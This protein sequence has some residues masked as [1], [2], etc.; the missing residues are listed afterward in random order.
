MAASECVLTFSEAAL[1]SVSCLESCPSRVFQYFDDLSKHNIALTLPGLLSLA[2]LLYSTVVDAAATQYPEQAYLSTAAITRRTHVDNT[3][4]NKLSLA[5]SAHLPPTGKAK[6]ILLAI[7][8]DPTR[9]PLLLPGGD[10]RSFGEEQVPGYVAGSTIALRAA[11][12]AEHDAAIDVIAFQMNLLSATLLSDLIT[13]GVK[14]VPVSV[15]LTLRTCTTATQAIV[16]LYEKF[17]LRQVDEIHQHWDLVCEQYLRELANFAHDDYRGLTSFWLL[18][19]LDTYALFPFPTVSHLTRLT[20][21]VKVALRALG[22]FHHNPDYDK[23][24]DRLAS[25]SSPLSLSDV[26]Q[27]LAL[28]EDRTAIRDVEASRVTA[29]SSGGFAGPFSVN[30]SSSSFASSSSNSTSLSSRLSTQSAAVTTAAPDSRSSSGGKMPSQYFKCSQASTYSGPTDTAPLATYSGQPS[31]PSA[32][33]SGQPA[34]YSGQ[35][36]SLSAAYSGQHSSPSAAFSG[37]SDLPTLASTDDTVLDSGC[38]PGHVITPGPHVSFYPISRQCVPVTTASGTSTITCMTGSATIHT[39]CHKGLPYNVQ[40]PGTSLSSPLLPSSLISLRTLLQH[41]FVVTK[42]DADTIVLQCPGTPIRFVHLHPNARGLWTFPPPPPAISSLASPLVVSTSSLALTRSQAT[43]SPLYSRPLTRLIARPH[44][45]ATLSPLSTT[46]ASPS[47]SS[48][49]SQSTSPSPLRSVKLDTRAHRQS[50]PTEPTHLTHDLDLLDSL[51]AAHGHVNARRLRLIVKNMLMED[52]NRPALSSMYQWAFYRKCVTCSHADMER[53]NQAATH[54]SRTSYLSTP[55]PGSHLTMDGSGAFSSATNSGMTSAWIITDTCSHHRVVCPVPSRA[56]LS[57]LTH[58]RQYIADS[59]TMPTHLRIDNELNVDSFQ[60]FCRDNLISLSACAPH[61]HQGNPIAESSVRCVKRVA[62]TNAV[63]ACTGVHLHDL[64]LQYAARQLNRSPTSSD[65]T[66]TNRSPETMWPLAPGNHPSQELHPWACLV[67]GFVGKRSTDPNNAPR[68]ALGIFVG[69]A[70]HTSGYLVYDLDTSAVTTYGYVDAFPTRFPL[71][72]RDL[73]GEHPATLL[74]GQWRQWSAFRLNE[75]ADGPLSEFLCGKQIQVNLPTSFYPSYKHSW[76]VLCQRPVHHASGIYSIRL[77]FTKYNGPLDELSPDDAACLTEGATPLFIDVLLSPLGPGGVCPPHIVSS[78]CVRALL[79][80]TFP[81]VHRLHEL[82]DANVRL[83]G[84]YPTHPAAA[85][86]SDAVPDDTFDDDCD[87]PERVTRVATDRAAKSSRANF[88]V[89]PARTVGSTRSSKAQWQPSSS[90]IIPDRQHM[91]LRPR[92]PQSI[93]VVSSQAVPTSYIRVLSTSPSSGSIG[94]EPRNFRE[95]RSHA[96]WPQ[97]QAAILKEV[98]GLESRGT[99]EA[100]PIADVPAG[101]TI[102]GSQ[103]VFRDKAVPKARL[104]VRGDQ[105]RPKPSSADTYAST[106][107]ATEVRILFSLATQ[108]NWPIHSCDIAQAFTQSHALSPGSDLYIHPPMGYPRTPGIVWRLK[109]PLYGLCTAPKAW[110]DTL[111]E[112]VRDYGFCSVNCSDT[113]YTYTHPSSGASIHLVFHVD[114]ILFSFSTDDV[115]SAFKKALLSRFDGTDDG[116]VNLFV[117]ISVTRDA[118][119]TLL[120][121]TPLA[122]SL[123]ADFG[124]TDCYSVRTPMD[125]GTLLTAQSDSDPVGDVDVE[126]F[127]HLVGTLLYLTTWTRPDLA[128][129]TNQLA[130]FM[131]NPAPKHMTAALRVL[132]YLKG[133][134][135][136]GITYTRD[137]PNSNRLVGFADADWASCTETRRSVSG[138]VLLLNGGAISW[139]SR[140]QKSV[141][142]STCEAEYVSASKA[143]DDIVF[144][145]RILS[146]AGAHQSDPTPLYEDNRGCRMMSENPVANSRSKHIDYRVHSLRE[147]VS[148]GNVRLVD[149]PTVDMVADPL[150]KNLAAPAFERH[151]DALLGQAKHSAP[152]LPDLTVGGPRVCGPRVPRHVHFAAG[153]KETSSHVLFVS[154]SRRCSRDH[155]ATV[156]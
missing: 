7:I 4:Y 60:S 122:E 58:L 151:R 36:S 56:A 21:P 125:P 111:K 107:S 145:R 48:S 133:T 70:P 62:R 69:H 38:F 46:P 138:Y 40:L 30:L 105:Q 108:N 2:Q 23:L 136:L 106:P 1:P 74:C 55:T 120:H 49:P 119:H 73:A 57:A 89:L 59:G 33:Y 149:C 150:T 134:V 140:Q 83:V 15:L 68:G 95:A 16:L 90:H 141:A 99:W 12:T 85:L 114:D 45:P 64:S 43:L 24:A 35:P 18:D 144:L 22:G 80:D 31:S 72:E 98:A 102:M 79:V 54:P 88:L 77:V 131:S 127:Q 6:T 28:L 91:T 132:R 11:A 115:G 86:V 142:L 3:N 128:F 121:Q 14:R 76:R 71:R 154:R 139:S 17:E 84:S 148:D 67:I 113:F 27:E 32:A 5:V 156:Y 143:S 126:R 66:G 26:V 112:F 52:P 8:R 146:D 10:L 147:R 109:K 51:H 103:F 96:S 39:Q 93:S 100:V 135:S 137:Q 104:V 101:V 37:Q 61:T 34:T 19:I 116:P 25:T 44:S 87:E 65:P 94:F 13:S 81:S 123:L 110:A 130:K 41:D 78:S 155:M 97:W 92:P 47:S 42:I 75:V 63:H 9:R 117:G 20:L 82:A 29:F 152:R 153:T 118:Y 124:M 50:V 53:P 129:A